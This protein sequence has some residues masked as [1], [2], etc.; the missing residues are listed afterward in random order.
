MLSMGDMSF[1]HA[2]DGLGAGG[3]PLI[4]GFRG[5]AFSPLMPEEEREAY[6]AAELSCTHP[7]IMVA[8]GKADALQYRP[9]RRHIGGLKLDPR[10]PWRWDA[11]ARQLCSPQ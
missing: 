11:K 4:A 3:E 2:L 5:L 1:Y 7:G 8:A 6:F 9:F 10:K